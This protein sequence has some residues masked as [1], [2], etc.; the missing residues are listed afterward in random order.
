MVFQTINRVYRITD[1]LHY[2]GFVVIGIT[3]KQ[4]IFVNPLLLLKIILASSLMLSYA[5]SF[6]DYKD[7]DLDKKYFILPLIPFAFF[8]M[9]LKP[10][11][12]FLC[13]FFVLISFLYSFDYTRLASHP[14]L[15]TFSNTTGSLILFLLG[16]L[17]EP[18][19]TRTAL[20]MLFVLGIY[21]TIA[22]L[23]HEKV[24]LEED[25]ARH[26]RTTVDVL[27]NKLSLCIRIL[28]GLSVLVNFMFIVF[29]ELLFF[30]STCIT[31]S[32]YFFGHIEEI[33]RGTRHR[34]KDLSIIVGMIY[35]LELL[36]LNLAY[37][38]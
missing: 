3:F 9:F 38:N 19:F 2:I 14:F 37:L 11:Q 18:G 26:R 4:G 33:D 6:N 13:L 12:I 36:L 31:F 24:H 5:F 22:Q 8:L 23:L 25:R 28:L 29:G 1:W 32:V 7:E 27:G 10:V 20:L 21:Q 16:Y 34:F 30:P 15:G 17:V 35:L